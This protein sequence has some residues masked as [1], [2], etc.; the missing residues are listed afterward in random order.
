MTLTCPALQPGQVLVDIAYSGVCN[1]PLSEVRGKRGLDRFLPHTLGHEGAGTVIA[2]GAEV[3][4]VV[5]GDHVVLSWIKGDGAEVASTCYQS[6]EGAVH[7]GAMSTFMRQTITCENRLTLLPDTM[8]LRE[9]ALL[10]CTIPT[11]AGMI[12]HTARVRS[13]SSVAI[14]GAGG[15]G[16]SAIMAAKL[17]GAELII[18]IDVAKRKLARARTLGA[19]HVI[20]SRHQDP[21]TAIQALTQQ[22][23]VDCAVEAVGKRDTMEAAFRAVR[24]RGGLCVLAGN[25]AYGERIALDPSDVMRGKRIVGPWGGESQLDRDVSVYATLFLAGKLPLDTLITHE[26]RLA[27]INKALAALEQGMVGG[28]LINMAEE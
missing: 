27:D 3:T 22:Q 1:T 7:S 16:L 23:G 20:D 19:T 5:P 13:G 21:L 24:D 18:A 11:G 8:P 25:V 28:A 9:A 14:F 26:Y 12:L 17:R 2:V 6:A 10:G 4:K 15:I